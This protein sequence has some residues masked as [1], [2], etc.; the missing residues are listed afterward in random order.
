M[1]KLGQKG[2]FSAIMKIWLLLLFCGLSYNTFAQDKTVDG[3]VFDK[4]S[5]DRLAKI[6]VRNTSNG[7]AV[8]NNLKGEFKI[9]AGTGDVLI[10]NKEGYFADTIKIQGNNTLAVYLKRTGIQLSQVDI[11]AK[12]LTPEKQLEATKRDY[13]KIYGYDNDFLSMSPGGGV[14]VS[15]DAIFNAFSKSAK[16]AEKLKGII[17]RDYHENV[18]DYRFNRTLV[19]NITGLKDE[20]LTDF[21]YKYRPG[22]YYVTTA[23]DY[24]FVRYIRNNYRRYKRN[25]GAFTLKPLDISK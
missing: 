12:K 5:K 7:E 10:F 22:Y 17:E 16:N 1:M 15:I 18:I 2:S 4:D 20:Q 13:T 19:G 3:I 9:K 11:N 25:P 14:G 8:Y 24:D 21:M 23:T 6:N